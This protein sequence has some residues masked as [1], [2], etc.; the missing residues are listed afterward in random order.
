MGGARVRFTVNSVS[1]GGVYFTVTHTGGT[2]TGTTRSSPGTY[3]QDI[4]IAFFD[5]T[6][7]RFNCTGTS[8]V[9]DNVSLKPFL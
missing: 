6:Q 4:N 1:G 9:I 5:L 7:I 2:I 8:C 3:T